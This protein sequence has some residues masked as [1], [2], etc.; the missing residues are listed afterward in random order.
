MTKETPTS[1]AQTKALSVQRCL[2]FGHS[3]I[4]HHS[5]WLIVLALVVGCKTPQVSDIVVGPSYSP[6]NVHR[7]NERLAK[8]VRRVAVLPL[9]CDNMQSEAE[10]GWEMLE[11]VLREE[12]GKTGKFELIPVPPEKVRQW[13]GHRT[14]TAEERLPADFFKLL[15]DEQGCDAVLFCRVTQ[16][17]AYPPLAVG[18][19]LKLVQAETPKLLWAVD[20]VIDAAEPCVVNG[21]RRYQQAQEQL[22]ASLADSRSILNSPRGFGRYAASAMFATL[23]ER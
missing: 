17:H 12:L 3:L 8:E 4:T 7:L 6:K 20:E 14:W 22:P 9:T 1:N 16:F 23:P 19:N 18:L 2:G 13:T 21:A 10:S 15:R 5:S 11:P